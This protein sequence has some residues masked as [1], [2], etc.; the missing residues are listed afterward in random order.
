MTTSKTKSVRIKGK[1]KSTVLFKFTEDEHRKINIP[2][3][4]SLERLKNNTGNQ[5]DWFNCTHRVRTA[6]DVAKEVCED[7]T[8]L[9]LVSAY[10]KCEAIEER[11][12]VVNHTKWEA[13][14]DEL[15][16]M[17]EAFDVVEELQRTIPRKIF[18]TA[19]IKSDTYLRDKYIHGK[20][21]K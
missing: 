3:R 5:T 10:Q 4:R 6:V 17:E 15:E 1:P 11:A 2:Y 8:I 18:A 13:T 20:H 7:V 19:A 14:K 9:A 12:R 21:W 16:W